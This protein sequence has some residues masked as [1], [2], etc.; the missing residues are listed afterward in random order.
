MNTSFLEFPASEMHKKEIF[1]A[2]I[3]IIYT[4][5][6]SSIPSG[7]EEKKVFINRS[8]HCRSRLMETN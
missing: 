1:V 3:I 8:K 5:M 6:K 2:S 7:Q 4:S